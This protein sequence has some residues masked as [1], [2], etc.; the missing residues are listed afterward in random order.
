MHK[1]LLL[2]TILGYKVYYHQSY[3]RINNFDNITVGVIVHDHYQCKWSLYT[4]VTLHIGYDGINPQDHS[5]QSPKSII[6]PILT[7]ARMKESD[8]SACVS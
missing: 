8:T 6:K 3:Q 2:K 4:I 1:V 5:L 7:N